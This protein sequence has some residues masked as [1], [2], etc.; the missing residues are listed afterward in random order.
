MSE[1]TLLVLAASHY[2]VPVIE[3][4]RRSGFRIITTD[5]I[6]ENPGHRLADRCY[7]VDTT[8]RHS[9][10]S[11]CRKEKVAGVISACTDVAVPT[12]AYIASNMG[13]PG[14]PVESAEICCY[15]MAFRKFLRE[16]DFP[17]PEA[18]C[19]TVSTHP[20]QQIFR[21]RCIIKPDWSSG[22]KGIFIVSSYEEFLGRI[23][24]SL[25][26]SPTGKGVCETFIEGFQGTCEGIIRR[27]KVVWRMITDRRTAELPYVTTCGHRVPSSLTREKQEE[28]VALIEAICQR[29]HIF[30]SVFDC[31]FVSSASNVFILEIS[32]RLGGNSLTSLVKYAAGFDIIDY[33]I[34]QACNITQPMPAMP[35]II[36][37]TELI[38]FGVMREGH[39]QYNEA[40]VLSLKN[41]LW[42]R[43]LELDYPPGVKVQPFING[44]HRLGQAIVC[45]HSSVELADR[46][47]E[48]KQRLSLRVL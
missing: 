9:V 27:G 35:K 43:E 40:E 3:Q 7:N 10:L 17:V 31:D 19:F 47:M 42:I 14:V 24:E 25:I 33:A 11:I 28:L 32:P 16:N 46:V 12:A 4:A 30:D 8:D 13:L 37:P 5:N 22:S 20:P 39:L 26:F 48:L 41:E 6:P 38:L 15:K 45:A 1:K 2:Q 23:K 29:L 21:E 18:H 44:R 36:L 34:H